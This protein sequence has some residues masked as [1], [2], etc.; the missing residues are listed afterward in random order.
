[1]ASKYNNVREGGWDSKRERKRGRELELLQRAG[2]IHD[3]QR[4]VRFTLI[5]AQYVNG[6]CVFRS[7]VYVADF[8]YRLKDDTFIV[9]DCK[10]YKT[11]LYKIKKKLMYERFGYLI[12][13]T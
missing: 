10:G 2:E 3:L 11:D 7:C 9:E 5:P 1:M 13:E 4:Q 8:T 6:K 12:R